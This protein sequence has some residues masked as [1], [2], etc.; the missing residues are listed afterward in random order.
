M[1]ETTDLT[2]SLGPQFQIAPIYLGEALSQTG[3]LTFYNASSINGTSFQAGN[4]SAAVAYILP[5]AGP[6]S[7]GQILSGTTAGVLSWSTVVPT[8]ASFVTIA[9]SSGLSAE[10]VLTGT[11]NQIVV[12]DN[13]AN[14]TVVLS[15]PQNIHTGA[16]PTFVGMTLS[17]ALAMG[18]AKITGMGNGTAATDA[19]AF[20]QIKVIQTQVFTSVSE[21]TTTTSS[22]YQNTSTTVSITPTSASNRILLLANGVVTIN[23][24]AT[25]ALVTLFRSTTNLATD[26]MARFSNSAGTGRCGATMAWVDSPATTSATTYTVKLRSAD[27]TNTVGWAGG[28][29]TSLIAMEIV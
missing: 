3:L 4:A 5:T 1:P 26:E 10:R 27:N 24:S 9:A 19:A 20:G 28:G 6:S 29:A 18:T 17:A 15:T 23:N 7:N 2:R 16:S 22:A 11:S 21:S 8:D 12:T 25:S 13:G 14:S